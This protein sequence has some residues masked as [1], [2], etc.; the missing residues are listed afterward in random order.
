MKSMAQ[1]WML[2]GDDI[3]D[4]YPGV[5]L[6]VDPSARLSS[7][8]FQEWVKGLLRNNRLF[9]VDSELIG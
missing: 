4:K 5:D 3:S 6:R 1:E 9:V 8:H 7:F 2:S